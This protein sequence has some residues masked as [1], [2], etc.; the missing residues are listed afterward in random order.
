[1][2]KTVENTIDIPEETCNME[3][4]EECKNVTIRQVYTL[5]IYPLY[6]TLLF[7]LLVCGETV[8]TTIV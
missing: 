8:S 4:V 5:D 6:R 2:E 3:P 7:L 1:M